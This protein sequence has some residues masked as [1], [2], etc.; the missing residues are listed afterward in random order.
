ME[1]LAA[2][3]IA[4][5]LGPLY[6][7]V[8][9]GMFSKPE[10]FAALVTELEAQPGLTV[11]WGVTAL[12]FGLLVLAF[13]DSWRA[14]WTVLVTLIGWLAT[15]KGVLMILAPEMLFGLGKGLLAPPSRARIWAVGPLVLG[16][17]LTAAGYGLI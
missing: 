10:R 3:I 7:I 11:G 8:A 12:A 15:I 2:Q 9:L 4:Q 13:H 6:V 17:F 16:A 14:D 1:P 5:I